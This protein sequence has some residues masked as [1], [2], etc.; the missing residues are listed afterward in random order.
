MWRKVRNRGGKFEA[1][2]SLG[3]VNRF[4]IGKTYA[5]SEDGE[6]KSSFWDSRFYFMPTLSLGFGK[7]H[8]FAKKSR[9]FAW[10]LRPNVSLWMPYNTTVVPAM[11]LELGVSLYLDKLKD[12]KIFAAK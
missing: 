9:P 12:L 4:N 11:G 7:D 6:V 8:L 10:H 3:L 5:V 2:M 1:A